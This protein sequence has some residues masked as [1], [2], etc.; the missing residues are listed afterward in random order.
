MISMP[1][2]RKTHAFTLIELLIVVAIIAILAA[3]AV[4]NFLEAQAR[5]KNS[6]CKADMRSIA[7]GVESYRVDFNKYPPD[8]HFYNQLTNPGGSRWP[9]GGYMTQDEV[10]AFLKLQVITTPIAY[11]TT[12]PQNVYGNHS[13]ANYYVGKTGYRWYVY[14]AAQW[15]EYMIDYNPAKYEDKG[16]IWSI[17]STG[18]DQID[19]FGSYIIFGEDV[20]NTIV[21]AGSV[22]C[23]YDP[24][25]GTVSAGDVVRWGP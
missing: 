5:S 10:N 6:R 18:P 13:F 1:T 17:S 19:N 20:L 12:V 21:F 25:N 9:G 15:K 4:P 23:L 22:G 2:V 8:A 14:W 7:T 3:I 11:L 24:T 16:P